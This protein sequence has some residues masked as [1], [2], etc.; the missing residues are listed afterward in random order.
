MNKYG[1]PMYKGSQI[2]HNE[3]IEAIGFAG[4]FLI[5]SN[6][7]LLAVGPMSEFREPKIKVCKVDLKILLQKCWVGPPSNIVIFIKTLYRTFICTPH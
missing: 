7:W 6:M 2:T 1:I 3:R 5:M 4:E